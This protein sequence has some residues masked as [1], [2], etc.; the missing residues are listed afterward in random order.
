MATGRAAFQQ[1]MRTSRSGRASATCPRKA[2]IPQ[3]A[4]SLDSGVT[5][6]MVLGWKAQPRM[7]TDR[8]ALRIARFTAV[9]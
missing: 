4:G 3:A 6:R 7:C 2:A 5:S 9:K 1:R 8:L